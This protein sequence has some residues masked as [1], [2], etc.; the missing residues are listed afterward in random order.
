MKLRDA[1]DR[2]MAACRRGD[3][4]AAERAVA[5][6]L[7]LL[8]RIGAGIG[9]EDMLRFMNWQNICLPPTRERRR[10]AEDA[11]LADSVF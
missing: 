9:R 7:M 5:D 6:L 1:W 4:S 8:N 3:R 11:W 2:L 10:A